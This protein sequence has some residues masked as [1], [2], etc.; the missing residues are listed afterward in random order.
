MVIIVKISA[1]HEKAEDDR[2]QEENEEKDVHEYDIGIVEGLVYGVIPDNNVRRGKAERAIKECIGANA[3]DADGKSCL[4]HIIFLLYSG[5]TGEQCGDNK[6]RKRTE[7]DCEDH[8]GNTK[9]DR[10][11][12]ELSDGITEEQVA[13]EGSECGREHGDVQIFADGLF[14][15]QTIDQNAYKGRPHIQK[16]E[17]VKAVGNDENVCREGLGIGSRSAE[18]DHQIAGESAQR[19]VK[20]GACQASQIEIVRDQL[21]GGRQNAEE[22]RKKIFEFSRIV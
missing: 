3:E 11:E 19:R 21:G 7:K 8:A 13:D 18:E 2:R 14:G 15:D 22:I 17:T 9:L 10:T 20:K 16:I 5:Y 12:I 1:V 4:I 6:S